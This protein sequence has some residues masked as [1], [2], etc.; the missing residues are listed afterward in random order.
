[1]KEIK[2][3]IRLPFIFSYNRI[4]FEILPI[5]LCD[6]SERATDRLTDR[7]REMMRM[8]MMTVCS[9]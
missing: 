3:N 8:M 7:Q 6:A 1:M 4:S 5:Y 9:F 2:R